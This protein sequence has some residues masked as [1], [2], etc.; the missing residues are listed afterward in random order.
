MNRYSD[1]VMGA[2]HIKVVNTVLFR[3][4]IFSYFAK[5]IVTGFV[6]AHKNGARIVY[7][8]YNFIILFLIY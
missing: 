1:D 3:R 8:L 6:K 5:L 4:I 7:V 2:L